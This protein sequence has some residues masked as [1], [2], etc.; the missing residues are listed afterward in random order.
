MFRLVASKQSTR[1]VILST[2]PTRSVSS[3]AAAA[4]SSAP[5]TSTGS[6]AQPTVYDNIIKL[7][8][9]DS[10]GARRVIPGL[11]GK[12][13]W[14]TAMMHEIDIGP[15]SCGAD[16]ERVNSDTWTE[17]LYGEGTTSGFDHVLIS[18]NGVETAKPMDWRE[19]ECLEEYWDKDELFPESRLASQITLTKAMDGMNVFVPDRLCDDIP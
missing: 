8:F 13:L 2:L 14:E 10:S 3:T 7:N 19:E 4:A 16:V 6:S 17:N 9:I 11:I 18:G 12:N 15:S 5:A 1:R